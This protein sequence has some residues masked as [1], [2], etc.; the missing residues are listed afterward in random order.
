MFMVRCKIPGGKVTAEQYLAIDD[1][2]GKYANG[3]LRITTRQGIQL[4]GVLK[5]QPEADHRRHQ[6]LPADAR[7]GPAATSNAT[8]WPA[9]R[10]VRHA[11]LSPSCK[12]PADDARPASRPAHRRLSRNLAQ[13]RSRSHERAAETDVEPIYGKV[14]LP[15]KFKT[16]LALP[17]DNCDRR[18]R[19]GP[20]PA[21]PSSRTAASSATTCWSAAAWA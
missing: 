3:T 11:G 13:R 10:P 14:Y 19:P 20:R 15:R 5:A 8:S 16:G 12:R 17:D 4:H 7:S 2:A 18:L 9:G 21:R 6:R 1:L